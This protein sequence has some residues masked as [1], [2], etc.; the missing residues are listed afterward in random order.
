M[1]F[2]DP[3]LDTAPK[4]ARVDSTAAF[5]PLEWR[6]ISLARS[7]RVT[8]IPPPQGRWQRL[9]AWFRAAPPL[10]PLANERLEAL[11]RLASDLW[12]GHDAVGSG[13]LALFLAAGF[14][15]AQLVILR[16][17]ISPAAREIAA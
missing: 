8:P 4:G 14:A 1:A 2:H 17:V 3:M 6:V 7:E 10:R 15:E 12:H 11:R 5:T 16:A 13:N 9:A